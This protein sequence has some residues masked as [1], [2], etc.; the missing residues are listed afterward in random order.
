MVT[1]HEGVSVMSVLYVVNVFETEDDASD[2]YTFDSE[3]E[4]ISFVENTLDLR[5]LYLVTVTRED[6]TVIAKWERFSVTS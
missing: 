2:R 6:V 5:H 4:A 1:Y 3:W